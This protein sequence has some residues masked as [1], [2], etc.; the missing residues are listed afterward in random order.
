VRASNSEDVSLITKCYRNAQ[1]FDYDAPNVRLWHQFDMSLFPGRGPAIGFPI[2]ELDSFTTIDKHH[3]E[4]LDAIFVPSKWAVDIVIKEI[5]PGC[6]DVVPL[7]VDTSIFYPRDMA[8]T[9]VTHFLSV[10][11]W[12]IRKG[13][14]VLIDAFNAAFEPEDRVALWMLSHNF[15]L[16]PDRNDGVDGNEQW[17]Q[18]YLSTKMG[19]SIDIIDRV[20]TPQQ[21]SNIMSE[22][23]CGVFPSR[24]EGWN[25]ELLE[26]MACGKEVIATNYSA[27]TE[28]ANSENCR[29]IEIDELEEAYDGKFFF[30]EE[31]EHGNWAQ[32]GASQFDQLVEH[33]RSVHKTKQ[34]GNKL[35]NH[36]GVATAED[37]TWQNSAET[38]VEVLTNTERAV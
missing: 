17:K 7:G 3:L 13:H 16:E 20:E 9:P 38:L 34:D 21:V 28:F 15:L 22:V 31:K 6:V 33:M 14:D 32:L 25:L 37:F 26:M 5:G 30:G 24:A 36:E 2:F 27:H 11:K 4:W 1:T 23:D 29:L 10:G 35:F 8:P 12:E 19:R 18:R